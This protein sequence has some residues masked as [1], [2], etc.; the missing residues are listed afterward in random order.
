MYVLFFGLQWKCYCYLRKLLIETGSVLIT[1]CKLDLCPPVHQTYSSKG[2]LFQLDSFCGYPL[3]WYQIR[4]NNLVLA[5]LRLFFL[6]PYGSLEFMMKFDVLPV[7]K[8]VSA[9][10]FCVLQRKVWHLHL[11]LHCSHCRLQFALQER[12][13][14]RNSQQ[15][16]DAKA[17]LNNSRQLF[18]I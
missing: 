17:V 5:D 2:T 12:W 18:Y 10:Q 4:P 1:H 15:K 14:Y 16:I 3:I 8:L 11:N 7:I 9:A 13:W 6:V